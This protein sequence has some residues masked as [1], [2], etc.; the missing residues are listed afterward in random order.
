MRQ[1]ALPKL[2][3]STAVVRKLLL[4]GLHNKTGA[5]PHAETHLGATAVH[6]SRI[7]P[8]KIP[9][10][11][12]GL[13]ENQRHCT[14]SRMEQ[15]HASGEVA[16]Q[17]I[18]VRPRGLFFFTSQAMYPAFSHEVGN[19]KYLWSRD[20]APGSP[21]KIGVSTSV[22][23]LGVVRVSAFARGGPQLRSCERFPNRT[24]QE[25]SSASKSGTLFRI[26]VHVAH[27]EPAIKHK[28]ANANRAQSCIRDSHVVP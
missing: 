21:Q 20:L 2:K 19:I 13:R 27:V 15:V 3:E 9:E 18:Y 4:A 24:E 23:L 14:A 28:T 17:S 8:T 5:R 25:E 16:V 7:P 22:P 10:E 11:V 1:K 26:D 6:F 12:Q